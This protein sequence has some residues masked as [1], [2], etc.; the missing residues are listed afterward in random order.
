MTAGD[1]AQWLTWLLFG[2]LALMVLSLV[3]WRYGGR[4]ALRRRDRDTARRN[5]VEDEVVPDRLSL[6]K[7][8]VGQ[9]DRLYE[10][11]V[12]PMTGTARPLPLVFVFHGGAGSPHGIAQASQFHRIARR[13]RFLVVYPA[14]VAVTANRTRDWNA[15]GTT[16]EAEAAGIDDDAFFQ[17]MLARLR[18]AFPVDDRRIYLAGLSKGGMLAYHLACRYGESIAALAV[19][20]AVMTTRAAPP[21]TPV[22]VLHIHGTADPRVPLDD[23]A[24][25]TGGRA[26][27]SVSETLALWRRVNGCAEDAVTVYEDQEARCVRYPAPATRADVEFC[28]IEGAGHA[29][30]GALRDSKA[31]FRPKGTL[32]PAS[33]Y[34]WTFFKEHPKPLAA[35]GTPAQRPASRRTDEDRRATR[36][37]AIAGDR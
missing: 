2:L 10:L 34:I 14:G 31:L 8:R 12:P 22:P 3:G 19:V 1:P 32:F 37:Q 4:L 20:A 11:Y 18:D 24:A 7:V 33:E 5:F 16:G 13:Q 23:D 17:A 6:Q 30:P 27:G 36:G 29:W 25:G 21:K 28:R 9:S 35:A 26:L 15:G